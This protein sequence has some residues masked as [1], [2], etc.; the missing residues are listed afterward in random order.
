MDGDM[1][2]TAR[3]R[4]GLSLAQLAERTKISLRVLN[5]LERNALDALPP[6]IFVRGFLRAYAREVGLDPETTVHAY[7]AQFANLAPAA[8]P[9]HDEPGDDDLVVGSHSM[10]ETPYLD[11]GR[12][13]Q[14]IGAALALAALAFT[15][16]AYLG[17]NNGGADPV[18]TAA[19]ASSA[20]AVATSGTAALDASA[21]EGTAGAPMTLTLDIHPTGPCWVEVRVNGETRVYRLMQGGERETVHASGD[22]VLR[23]GDPTEFAFSINGRPARPLGMTSQPVTVRITQENLAEF[24]G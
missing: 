9:D 14:N 18:T 23:V 8:P 17:F 6:P 1:L 5:A 10:A 19:G 2:R 12:S 22:V 7:M 3:E 16:V 4:H 24:R 20:G 21:G 13:R 15:V 11:D